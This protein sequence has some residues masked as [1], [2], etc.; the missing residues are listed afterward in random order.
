M[1]ALRVFLRSPVRH[2]SSVATALDYALIVAL[3]AVPIT[4]IM[5][6]AGELTGLLHDV[7]TYLAIVPAVEPDPF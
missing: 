6:S 1:C 4:E 7:G 3:I 2:R 5:A